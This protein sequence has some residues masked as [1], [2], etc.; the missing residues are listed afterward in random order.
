M[1]STAEGMGG[2]DLEQVSVSAAPPSV[3]TRTSISLDLADLASDDDNAVAVVKVASDGGIEVQPPPEAS[4]SSEEERQQHGETK[5][6]QEEEQQKEEEHQPPHDGGGGGGGQP[7]SSRV[8]EGEA[9]FER[10]SQQDGEAAALAALASS[11]EG[12]EIV[13]APRRI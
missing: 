7:A 11:I 2:L 4:N 9:L 13:G 5:R 12:F 3:S 10:R 6:V 1:A 8:S